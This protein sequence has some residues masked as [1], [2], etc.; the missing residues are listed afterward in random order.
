MPALLT[1][2]AYVWSGGLSVDADGSPRAYHEDSARG[3]DRLANAGKPGKWFGVVTMNGQPDGAPVIQ[4]AGDPAPGFYVS[5]TA[6]QDRSRT[7]WDPRRYVDSE[8]VPYLSA[9]RELFR[10]RAPLHVGDLAMAFYGTAEVGLVL[11]D[12]GPAGKFGEASIAAARAL[13]INPDP[14]KGGTDSSV[15]YVV[16]R[17]TAG[18]WPK[19]VE[20][21]QGQARARFE[22]WGGRARLDSALA[23]LAQVKPA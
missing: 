14:R 3:L 19:L 13:G 22:T 2:D 4:N 18:V 20:L 16:F 6:L 10:G 23:S 9:P 12:V 21:F 17:G 15:S 7:L 5:P 8:V 1:G 11:A